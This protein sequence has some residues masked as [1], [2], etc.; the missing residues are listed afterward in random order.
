MKNLILGSLF[1]GLL[2]VAGVSRAQ[3]FQCGTPVFSH[4]PSLALTELAP[5]SIHPFSVANGAGYS[6]TIGMCQFVLGGKS[7]D[8]LDVSALALG[9]VTSPTGNPSGALQLGPQLG[10]FNNLVGIAALFT[11]YAADGN[12]FLQ[13]GRPGTAWGL[14]LT[15]PLS[16][17][18]TSP[19]VGVAANGARAF[20][21]GGTLVIP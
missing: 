18:V 10:T 6:A 15:I 11:P 2:C 20:P 9:S 19:P 3:T 7:W 13:G 14:V 21:R 8:L 12:G 17:G 16:F 5:S 4:G 1:A